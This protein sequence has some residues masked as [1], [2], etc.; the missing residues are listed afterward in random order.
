ML[1]I[2]VGAKYLKNLEMHFLWNTRAC[3]KVEIL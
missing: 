2:L 1:M 3:V